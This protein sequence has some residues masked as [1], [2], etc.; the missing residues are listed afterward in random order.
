MLGVSLSHVSEPLL[1]SKD[2]N[3]RWPLA[4]KVLVAGI[5]SA[6][7]WLLLAEFLLPRVHGG[8]RYVVQYFRLVCAW[9]LVGLLVEQTGLR[10][11]APRLRVAALKSLAP[12]RTVFGFHLALALFWTGMG[13][14]FVAWFH[15]GLLL[16]LSLIF[17]GY[18]VVR[19]GWQAQAALR[20]RAVDLAGLQLEES[21]TARPD[22][23]HLTD[24]HLTESDDGDMVDWRAGQRGGNRALQRLLVA[25]ATELTQASVILV[26]GDATDA[27][28]EGEW[29]AFFR[30]MGEGGVLDRVVLLPGNHE[31]NIPRGTSSGLRALRSDG[32]LNYE[33][34]TERALRCLL[35]MARVQGER[36]R[37]LSRPPRVKLSALWS[38]TRPEPKPVSRVL[39][40][41]Y[42][43]DGLAEIRALDGGRPCARWSDVDLVHFNDNV[44][45]IVAGAFPM[46]VDVPGSDFAVLL[47]DSTS[48]S[49]NTFSNAFG[50]IK[51]DQLE[52]LHTLVQLL[53][54]DVP[55]R[56][57][58]LAM[59]HHIGEGRGLLQRTM[60]V[61]DALDLL[62][63]LR[64]LAPTVLFNGHRHIEYLGQVKDT[65][66]G[67]GLFEV[68]SGQSTTL[69]NEAK[70]VAERRPGF[71]AFELSRKPDG[72]R[73]SK[74]R[75]LTLAPLAKD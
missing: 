41:S 12:P 3:P 20:Y 65:T 9:L 5:L 51:K 56:P 63:E 67:V 25:H 2:V 7:L 61:V 47:L 52:R 21:P 10:V 68:V 54:S 72:I 55:R 29:Q 36:A 28:T 19:E 74:M 39:L 15:G 40:S 24:L 44:A 60:G 14:V 16:I 59:H 43:D 32:F 49:A 35:A 70:P 42:L 27:G 73:I 48:L 23:V 50:E 33:L 8:W 31:L 57:I 38:R 1:P 26:T 30:M 37:V 69:G 46:I 58:L 11:F 64:P 34:R 13:I 71:R 6:L 75:T 18:W 22:V 53:T 62:D 66:A 4:A 45:G 17:A